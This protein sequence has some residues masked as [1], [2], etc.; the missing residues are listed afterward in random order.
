LKNNNTLWGSGDNYL[1]QLGLGHTTDQ[2]TFVQLPINNIKSVYCDGFEHTL[3]LKNDNTLW[4]TGYNKY[5]QLGLGHTTNQHTFVQLP[6]DNIKSVSCG[7]SHT[8][9]LKNDNTLWGSGHNYHGQLGLG[10]TNNQHTFIQILQQ[11]THAKLLRQP[12]DNI[13]SVFCGFYCTLIL[14]NDNTLW[15]TGFNYSGQLGLGNTNDQYTFIQIL[16]QDTPTKLLRQPIDNVKSV[17]CGMCHTLIL[18]N[19]NTLWGTGGNSFGQLGLGHIKKQHT[20]VQILQ[21]DTPAKLLHRP[22]DN[23]K[24]VSCGYHHTFILKNDDT[25][26]VSGWNQIGKLGSGHTN[27]QNTFIQVHL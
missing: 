10:N 4:G 22:I 2:Y 21:Q 16:Q 13:R 24:S 3:I 5:G 14:K 26:W 15:G 11:D 1:G 7:G 12:I 8:L 25:L 9:I 19:D 6:I 27:R 23:I 20:F 18:K 17:S